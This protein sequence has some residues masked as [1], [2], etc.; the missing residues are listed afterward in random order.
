[1][2]LCKLMNGRNAGVLFILAKDIELKHTTSTV[3]QPYF[4]YINCNMRAVISTL[5][6]KGN[7]QVS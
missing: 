6:L 7:K 1:M 3:V 4:N 2:L 5:Q